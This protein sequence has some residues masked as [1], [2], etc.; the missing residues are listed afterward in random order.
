LKY[1]ELRLNFA[2]RDQNDSKR[3][4]KTELQKIKAKP[5]KSS[6]KNKT[7]KTLKAG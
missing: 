7:K 3:R 4:A 2:A 5:V 6:Q 1:T